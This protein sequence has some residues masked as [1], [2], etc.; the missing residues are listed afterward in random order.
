LE[1]ILPLNMSEE[2]SHKWYEEKKKAQGY[3]IACKNDTNSRKGCGHFCDECLCEKFRLGNMECDAC[4]SKINMPNEIF[5]IE[6][7]CSSCNTDVFLLGDYAKTICDDRHVHCYLCLKNAVQTKQC[8]KC[9]KEIN[10][11]QEAL[12]SQFLYAKCAICEEIRE[13]AFFIPKQCCGKE[14]CGICQAPNNECKNCG[15]LLEKY[16]IAVVDKFAAARR[17][18][19][20]RE[21]LKNNT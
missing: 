1:E 11:A 21:N 15:S 3:C 12:I 17:L 2:F 4:D 18:F 10:N 13:R 8:Q 5:D 7:R 16:A 9:K 6:V 14:I 19:D 20:I